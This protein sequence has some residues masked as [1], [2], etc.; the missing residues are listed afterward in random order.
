MSNVRRTASRSGDALGFVRVNALP[1]WLCKGSGWICDG[2]GH[3]AETPRVAILA[4]SWFV[5]QPAEPPTSADVR[6]ARAF[7]PRRCHICTD[8]RARF[9]IAIT[10]ACAQLRGIDSSMPITIRRIADELEATLAET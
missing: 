10:K 3:S 5:G 9:E 6:E 8:P 1:C 2:E 4:H 7:N